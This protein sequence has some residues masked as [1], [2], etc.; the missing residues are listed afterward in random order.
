MHPTTTATPTTHNASSLAAAARRL[1]PSGP[2]F[3]RTFQHHRPYICPFE[4]LI[5]HVPRGCT[6][7]DAG[8][9]AGLFLGLLA[10]EGRIAR[11]LGIDISARAIAGARGMAASAAP[12][13][14]AF[15]RRD[16]GAFW[17][18]ER[19]DAVSMID[20][21]HHV[22]PRDQERFFRAAMARVRPGGRLIYKDMAPRPRWRAAMNRL[23]DLILAHQWIHEVPIARVESWAAAEGSR[24]ASAG[25]ATRFWYAHEWR[26]FER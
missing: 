6:L 3:L 8:C 18:D 9:G 12:G 16:P 11:G 10:C 24:V 1:Y 25:S 22:G 21:L 14:L 19:F 4:Q 13:V 26:V 17:P 7:L 5:P 2:V 23:H 15:E 20:V